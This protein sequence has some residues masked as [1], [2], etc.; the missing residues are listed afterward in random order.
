MSRQAG[1]RG[2]VSVIKDQTLTENIVGPSS[3]IVPKFRNGAA[4]SY[5]VELAIQGVT[6]EA[7]VD[8]GSCITMVSKELCDQL[9]E[10]V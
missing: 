7:L 1:K 5:N 4:S 2:Q 9:G 8:T 6:F 3:R 10:C